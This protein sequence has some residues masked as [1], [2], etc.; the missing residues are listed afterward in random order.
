METVVGDEVA[1][2][3]HIPDFFRPFPPVDLDSVQQRRVWA[4]DYDGGL[5]TINGREMHPDRIDAGIE[6]DSAEIWTFRNNGNNW[7]H[8]IH[9][10]LSE[11]LV[12]EVNGIPVSH[13]S[14]QIRVNARGGQDFQKVFTL[15]QSQGKDYQIGKNVLNG[16]WCRGFRRDIALLGRG[17]EITM[18]N[19]WPDYLGK[20]VLHCH[21]VVHEDHTM[22][23]RWDV[24]PPGEG[25][26][27][28]RMAAEV[29]GTEMIPPHVESRPAQA[30][31]QHGSHTFDPS[32][33]TQR[34]Q[35]RE[36]TDGRARDDSQSPKHPHG[37]DNGSQA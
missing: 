32:M 21:N 31:V 28:P 19:R 30:T 13:D 1:D 25:F 10:H 34:R 36:H 15:E 37:H 7:W 12:L 16:P 14:I 27:G 11:W 2:P 26:E 24:V 8:P 20:Y 22:M 4:F 3:S 18:F 29:Y 35:S 17:T 33:K 5:W 6:R 9:N 23:I